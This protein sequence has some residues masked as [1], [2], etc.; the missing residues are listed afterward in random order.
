MNIMSKHVRWSAAIIPVVMMVGLSVIFSVG[1][2]DLCIP[3]FALDT[4]EMKRVISI[5]ESN[6]YISIEKLYEFCRVPAPCQQTMECEGKI[7]LVKGYVDYGNVFDKTHYPNLPYEKIRIYDKQK[8]GGKSLEVWAIAED[9]SRIF[10]HILN[11]KNHPDK[12]IYVKG[13][14]VGIDMP[15]MGPCQRGIKLEIDQTEAIFF[16]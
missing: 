15:I 8:K 3:G 4:K 14:I 10:E 6:Q 16:Q 9:N 2:H 12:K 11:H 13:V 5:C 7:A 1:C